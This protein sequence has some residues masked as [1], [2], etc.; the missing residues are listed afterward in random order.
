MRCCAS[1]CQGVK[2]NESGGVVTIPVSQLV[3]PV[4]VTGLTVNG[5]TPT[6]EPGRR[7]CIGGRQF[8]KKLV[9][10]HIKV[11]FGL[12]NTFSTPHADTRRRESV[13]SRHAYGFRLFFGFCRPTSQPRNRFARPCARSSKVQDFS[14]ISLPRWRAA[15]QELPDWPG[16]CGHR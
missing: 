10:T 11:T 16:L 2:V 5:N 15:A 13:Y 12:V 3:L 4:G 8:G 1:R 6:P 9:R 14:I 7:R